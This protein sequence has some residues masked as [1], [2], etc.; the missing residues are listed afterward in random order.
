MVTDADRFGSLLLEGFLLSAAPPI[1][2]FKAVS[3]R[4]GPNK[5]LE[6]IDLSVRPGEILS[7]LG[8][9]GCGKTTLLRVAAG[10]VKPEEGKVFLNGKDITD[11]PANYRELNTIFQN[12][13]LFQ[14]LNVREN[15][16]FGPKIAK[17]P[18]S[19]IE[20]ET[21]RLLNLVQLEA[22]AGQAVTT[23]SGGQKQRVALA[24]ALIMQPR[25][26]LLDE[27]FAALDLKLRQRMLLELEHLQR[28]VGITFVF[29]THDQSEAMSISHRVAVMRAGSVL[30]VDEPRR[31]YEQPEDV[32]TA[33]FFGEAVCIAVEIIEP[34]RAVAKDA[35]GMRFSVPVDGD[36]GE[37][38]LCLR[39]EHF[40]VAVAEDPSY[41]N[42]LEGEI[43]DVVFLGSMS[44]L[45]IKT[46]L[47]ELSA[48]VANQ[49]S[50][51]RVDA[52]ARGSVFLHW[53]GDQGRVL[54]PTDR[55]A[56]R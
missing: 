16:A 23:L 3:H 18:K 40:H 22:Q 35:E 41:E 49:A 36:P 50:G 13:A 55:G 20:A 26:L 27:P 11:L 38:V 43:S 24:R 54:P 33:N 56:Q 52:R 25:V 1:L 46:T 14:H 9:S 30:Q 53:H 45:R 17:W 8:P 2:E 12:Y 10:F 44:K 42:R 34:G 47:G 32:F 4:F 5:V 29:V 7:L 39:P 31:L 21:S 6:N 48:V 15:I 37:A 19:K 51:L 28:E